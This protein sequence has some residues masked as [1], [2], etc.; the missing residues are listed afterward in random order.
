MDRPPRRVVGRRDSSTVL[1]IGSAATNRAMAIPVFWRVPP[2]RRLA[3]ERIAILEHVLRVSRSRNRSLSLDHGPR[4][5]SSAT[6]DAGIGCGWKG[7]WP[8]HIRI[9]CQHQDRQSVVAWS[10]RGDLFRDLKT[11]GRVR[12]RIRSNARRLSE[13]RK[14]KAMARVPI[15]LKIR[16]S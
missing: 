13:A 4:V 5:N 9:R 16:S 1:M 7:P 8:F 14:P 11:R 3:M 2:R 6:P 12:A 10:R 15:H